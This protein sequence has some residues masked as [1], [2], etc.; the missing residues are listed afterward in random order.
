MENGNAAGAPQKEQLKKLPAGMLDKR[1]LR[2]SIKW[3][4][5]NYT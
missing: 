2:Q 5:P 3:H 1:A 4:F